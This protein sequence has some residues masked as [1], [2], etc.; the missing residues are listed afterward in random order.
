MHPSRKQS[1]LCASCAVFA[2]KLL[3][4][5]GSWIASMQQITICRCRPEQPEE[6]KGGGGEGRVGTGLN[7]KYGG[8]RKRAQKKKEQVIVEQGAEQRAGGVLDIS[9]DLKPNS[10][11]GVG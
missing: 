8:E 9:E 2:D 3:Q 1:S 6:K 7:I 5:Q 4:S 10:C 11:E